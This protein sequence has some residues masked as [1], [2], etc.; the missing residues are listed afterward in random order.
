MKQNVE[1]NSEQTE[2]IHYKNNN[3]RTDLGRMHRRSILPIK[4]SQT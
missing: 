4:K 1:L 3:H 2:T